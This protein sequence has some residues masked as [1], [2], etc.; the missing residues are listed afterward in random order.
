MLNRFFLPAVLVAL[1][2]CATGER[3]Q[4]MREGMSKDEVIAVLGNPNGFNVVAT[5]RRYV[6]RTG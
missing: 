3:M 2:G 4:S 1:I 6:M 5:M